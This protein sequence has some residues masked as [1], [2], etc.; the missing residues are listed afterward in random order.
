M[1]LRYDSVALFGVHVFQDKLEMW[2]VHKVQTNTPVHQQCHKG[3][4][5]LHRQAW[6][7]AV[8]NT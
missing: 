6:N 3:W 8:L 1:L 7:H 5:K 4:A 2:L